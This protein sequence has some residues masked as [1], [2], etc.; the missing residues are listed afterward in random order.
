MA[1]LVGGGVISFDGDG[2]RVSPSSAVDSVA[3]SDWCAGAQIVNI[4][5]KLSSMTQLP[6]VSNITSIVQNG[7]SR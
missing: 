7:E 4:D 6:V 2:S 3:A 5:F 1:E